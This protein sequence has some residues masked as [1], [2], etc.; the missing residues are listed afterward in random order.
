M[1]KPP[2]KENHHRI[3]WVAA[4]ANKEM[5]DPYEADG[6]LEIQKRLSQKLARK[7]NAIKGL[8]D[9]DGERKASKDSPTVA[10]LEE[11][12]EEWLRRF[13]QF[14]VG[15]FYYSSLQYSH[16][17]SPWCSWYSSL[18]IIAMDDYLE[19]LVSLERLSNAR[20]PESQTIEKLIEE[21]LAK[22][23]KYLAAP[24]E[25]DV[26]VGY[27]SKAHRQWLMRTWNE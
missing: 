23:Q 8:V 24:V 20:R 4:A 5:R 17:T 26:L 14:G 22:V 19:S 10:D 2:I 6:I 1:E 15:F 3:H 11:W 27:E 25:E 13:T 9:E 21:S 7:E 16:S 12:K 18:G